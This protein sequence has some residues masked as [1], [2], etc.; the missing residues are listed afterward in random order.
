MRHFYFWQNMV[1]IHQVYCLSALAERHEVHWLVDEELLQERAKQGWSLPNTGKIHVRTVTPADVAGILDS[2]PKDV[3]HVFG[4]RA[5]AT[6]PTLIR[7]LNRRGL[8]YAHLVEIPDGRGWTLLLKRLIYRWLAWRCR[9]AEFMAAM[10]DSG[11]AWYAARGVKNTFPFCYTIA[12]TESAETWPVGLSYRFIIVARLIP[13]KRHSVLLRALAQVP[14]DWTLECVGRGPLEDDLRKLAESLGL[15]DRITWTR[16]LPN[17]VAREHISRADTLVL[18]SE[19]EGW[20]AVVNEA[21]AE[22]TRVVVSD[23]CGAACLLG[24]GDVGDAFPADDVEALAN[25]LSAQLARGRVSMEE[26]VARRSLHT[27]V[28]GRAM[29]VYFEK[30]VEGEKPAPPWAKKALQ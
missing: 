8:R 9:R 5:C 26:R 11:A 20:G 13:L 24:L 27:K 23:V 29:A 18:S 15:A 22:G 16:S 19:W 1:A 17:A 12:D 25:R 4:P 6:G 3:L 21:L 14:S 7:E 2:A 10:G 30:I 28:N